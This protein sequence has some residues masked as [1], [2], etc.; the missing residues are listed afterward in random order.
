LTSWS[1]VAKGHWLGV[2]IDMVLPKEWKDPEKQRMLSVMGHFK[3]IFKIIHPIQLA[4]GKFSP[5]MRM[6]LTAVEMKD[7]KGARFTNL[8]ELF[9]D[10]VVPKLV[11]D[12]S[13]DMGDGGV[14]AVSWLLYNVRQSMPIFGS[15]ILQAA[16][17]ETSVISAMAR[18]SGVDVRDVRKVPVAQRK[19]E[20]IN[21]EVNELTKKLDDAKMLKD[22]GMIAAAKEDIKNY[23]NYNRT[24][25][26][27]GFTKT[28]IAFVNKKLRPLELKVKEGIELTDREEKERLQ[29]KRRRD[30]IYQKAIQVLGR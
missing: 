2:P 6:G 15:E 14:T 13:F 12:S 27:L 30:E 3:D 25:S 17:G 11:A 20:E 16:S 21:S 7:W 10:G 19:F 23:D 8:S 26:R 18:M 1:G 28:Q 5:A 9:E 4:R 24:K 22:N 29:L